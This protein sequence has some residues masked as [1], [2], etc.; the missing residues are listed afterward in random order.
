MYKN[1]FKRALD[2]ILSLLAIVILSPVLIALAL[3][4]KLTSKGPVLF[5]QKRIGIYKSTFYILKFRSMRTDTPKDM[6]THLLSN[7]DAYITPV[8]TFLRKTSLD[9]LPQLF[10]ILLGQM[11][12][13]GP[14]PALW[15][16]F[17]LISARDLNGSNDVRPGLTGLAQINGRDEL[18]IAVKSGFDGDYIKSITLLTDLKIIFLT[19]FKVFSAQG[20]VEGGT[21]SLEQE[22]ETVGAGKS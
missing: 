1:F 20:V 12:I 21:S 8:G 5:K 14:R 6:P 22:K 15:N 16:Q 11:A 9:E 19:V 17:D 4:V 2:A 7:P 18:P 3:L 13:V 10:N